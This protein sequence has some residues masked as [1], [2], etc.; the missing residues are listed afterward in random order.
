MEWNLLEKTTFWVE[1]IELSEANLGQVAAAAASALGLMPEEVIVVDVRPGIVAFDLL[2]RQ[3]AAES[4]AGKEA[5][6]LKAL[7]TVSGVSLG[8]G[9]AFTR[10]ACLA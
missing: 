1:R 6:V 9:R 2:R 4:I 3:V 10:K 7:A 8:E 5:D